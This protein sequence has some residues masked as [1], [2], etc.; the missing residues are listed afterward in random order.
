MHNC[1]IEK[2]PLVRWMTETLAFRLSGLHAA[3]LIGKMP[4]SSSCSRFHGV[5]VDCCLFASSVAHMPESW[6]TMLTSVIAKQ[7]NDGTERFAAATTAVTLSSP[8]RFCLSRLSFLLSVGI[9]RNL[10][11]PT[12]PKFV[13]TSQDF[14]SIL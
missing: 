8:L 4:D 2:H 13:S 11:N 3:A 9:G 10:A 7:P 12:N 14:Q 5:E 1:W 6:E